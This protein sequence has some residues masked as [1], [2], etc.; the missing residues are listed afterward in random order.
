MSSN[1]ARDLF[2]LV[3]AIAVPQHQPKIPRLDSRV[4][5]AAI[6]DTNSHLFNTHRYQ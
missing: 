6:V 4:T 2:A 5:N 3:H 1:P